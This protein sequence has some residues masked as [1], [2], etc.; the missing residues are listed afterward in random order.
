MHLLTDA[1]LEAL[2]SHPRLHV[3]GWDSSLSLAHPLVSAVLDD[4]DERLERYVRYHRLVDRDVVE[5]ERKE[6]AEMEKGQHTHTCTD[7]RERGWAA[8]GGFARALVHSHPLTDALAAPLLVSTDEANAVKLRIRSRQLHGEALVQG[9]E[10]SEETI[11]ARKAARA[12]QPPVRTE[13]VLLLLK[14]LCLLLSHCSKPHVFSS[15]D[16]LMAL[17]SADDPTLVMAA[18]YVLSQL[19]ATQS[20]QLTFNA[21]Q[22]RYMQGCLLYTSP[23][24]R[25]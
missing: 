13:L 5:A 8:K 14:F 1:Q 9:D 25:D 3:C 4:F 20:R 6:H 15:V 2:L 17:L 23:S 11:A 10:E 18:L 12:A 22:G 24:P 7:I 19:Q 21:F 16:R